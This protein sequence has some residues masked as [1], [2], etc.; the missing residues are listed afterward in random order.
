MGEN[1]EKNWALALTC[2][3]LPAH[4]SIAACAKLFMV[5]TFAKKSLV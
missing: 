3:A 5:T 4:L 2:Q 1:F